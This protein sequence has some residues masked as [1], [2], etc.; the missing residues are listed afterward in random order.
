MQM[1]IETPFY[2]TTMNNDN[3]KNDKCSAPTRRQIEKA[4][5]FNCMQMN[6]QQTTIKT[7]F[8]GSPRYNNSTKRS[9]GGFRDK[10]DDNHK[11][12]RIERWIVSKAQPIPSY[13]LERG[14]ILIHEDAQTVATWID[15]DIKAR[16]VEAIFDS[17]KA[18]AICTTESFL[19]YYITL[20][21][22]ISGVDGKKGTI[23]EVQRRKGCSLEFMKQRRAILSAAKGNKD[24]IRNDTQGDYLS[25]PPSMMDECSRSPPSDEFLKGTLERVVDQFHTNSDRDGQLMSLDH[26]ACMT[27]PDTSNS[28][29][30]LRVAK[31]II[32]NETGI[33]DIIGIILSSSYQD[34][35]SIKVRHSSLTIMANSLGVL[36]KNQ[37]IFNDDQLAQEGQEWLVH[38]LLPCLV[39]DIGGCKSLHNAFLSSKCLN[40]LVKNCPAVR[41][42]AGTDRKLMDNLENAA[43]MGEVN[44]LKLEREA[45]FTI[46][47]LVCH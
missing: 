47:A 5:I 15:A 29:T 36:F 39:D 11:K 34:E 41:M 30:S 45:K 19:K 44:H 3:T 2:Y 33:R 20:Y 8:C 46:N 31:M 17:D 6:T 16:S 26:L 42:K 22:A 21:D 23:I 4:P 9:Y 32:E 10:S 25:I 38:S 1:K 27:N 37:N 40:L 14:T 7:D 28:Q 43:T 18:L 35:V 12:Q 24:T 13:A